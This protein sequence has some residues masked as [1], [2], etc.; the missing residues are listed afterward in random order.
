MAKEEKSPAEKTLNVRALQTE[1]APIVRAPQSEEAPIVRAPQWE[2]GDIQATFKYCTAPFDRNEDYIREALINIRP[3][4]RGLFA[5]EGQEVYIT[6]DIVYTPASRPDSRNPYANGPIES[7][8]IAI[9]TKYGLWRMAPRMVTGKYNHGGITTFTKAEDFL[10][11]TIKWL[12]REVNGGPLSQFKF[13]FCDNEC[14]E[15]REYWTS[16]FVVH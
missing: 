9:A 10:R 12:K 8:L 13:K 4:P 3:L 5:I 6:V 11:E 7:R 1:E 2:S 14:I 15:A 16:F